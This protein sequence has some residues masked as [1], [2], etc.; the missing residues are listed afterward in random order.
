[1]N[2]PGL[3]ML[4]TLYKVGNSRAVLIPAAFIASCQIE[5]QVEL[6][7]QHDQMVIKSVKRPPLRAGWF[8]PSMNATV[9][10]NDALQDRGWDDAHLSSDEEWEW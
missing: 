1:M 4:T 3:P 9:S 6:L 10:A 7:L 5:E 8:T 2:L